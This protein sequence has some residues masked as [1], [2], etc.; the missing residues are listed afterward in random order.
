MIWEQ[1]AP[2]LN[3]NQTPVW[4]RGERVPG[5]VPVPTAHTV[6]QER[7]ACSTQTPSV[8]QGQGLFSYLYPVKHLKGF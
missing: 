5:D 2:A 1:N 7:G 3:T 4:F 8:T 6:P